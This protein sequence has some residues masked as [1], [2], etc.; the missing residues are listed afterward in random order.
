M[1]ELALSE[2][3]QTEDL[4]VGLQGVAVH[5]DLLGRYLADQLACLVDRL[6]L[7]KLVQVYLQELS[8]LCQSEWV[9]SSKAARKS[10][11]Q[12]DMRVQPRK[13]G[14]GQGK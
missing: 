7:V 11:G 5:L 1:D 10:G 8:G 3:L 9:K 12:E 14:E 13:K 4:I 6:V 2:A